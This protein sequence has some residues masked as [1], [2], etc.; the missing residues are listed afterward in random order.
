MPAVT[1]HSVRLGMYS[2]ISCSV[3]GMKPGMIR[4][5]PFSIQMPG[6]GERC[7]R[8]SAEGAPHGGGVQ[9]ESR[10]DDVHR[11]RGPDPGHQGVLAVQAEEEVLGAAAW[12]PPV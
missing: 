4:P 7:T 11:D 9:E 5:M 1:F 6:E 12:A 10:G 8:R 2:T 3:L